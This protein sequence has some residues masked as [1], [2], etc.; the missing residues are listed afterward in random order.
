MEQYMTPKEFREY[1]RYSRSL[2]DKMIRKGL[3]IL[4]ADRKVT[5]PVNQ[6]VNWIRDTYNK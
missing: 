5:I 6:A 2:V 4:K 1:M 3:P